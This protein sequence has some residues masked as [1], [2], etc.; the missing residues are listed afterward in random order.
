MWSDLSAFF[1]S[2]DLMPHGSCLLWRPDLFW[3]HTVSDAIIA[4]SYFSIPIAMLIFIRKRP[5]FPY[6]WVLGLFALFILSCGVTHVFGLWTLWVPD[7]HWEAVAKIVTALASAT[8]AIVLWPML[9]SAVAAPTVRDMERKNSILSGEIALRRDAEQALRQLNATLE[10]EVRKRTADLETARAAAEAAAN[11]RAQVMRSLSHE[12]ATPLNAIL[13]FAHLI[14]DD[15]A[16]LSERQRERIDNILTAGH[17]LRTLTDDLAVLSSLEDDRLTV[18][19]E[20]VD[21]ADRVAFCVET[22]RDRA[23]ARDVAIVLDDPGLRVCPPVTADPAR[24]GQILTNLL[25]NAIKYNVEGGRVTVSARQEDSHVLLTVADT[26][27]GI[28]ADRQADMFKPF[29]R[30]GREATAIEGSGIGLAVSKRL[31]ELMGGDI[32]IES[33]EGRGTEVTLTLRAAGASA[34]LTAPPGAELNTS[35]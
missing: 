17:L 3:T 11:D 29:E 22:V 2:E 9:P 8:T 33:Q 15:R 27:I 24:L 18:A 12:I 14:A 32:R 10:S 35:T 4:L 34:D 21:L 16:T 7:Y 5:D 19:P 1:S 23:A 25:S 20:A 28:P 31:V 30:L 13:G 26:G 6:P